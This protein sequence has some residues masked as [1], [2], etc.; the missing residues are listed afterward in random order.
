MT[1]LFINMSTVLQP[2]RQ[3]DDNMTITGV[4]GGDTVYH[5]LLANERDFS[6]GVGGT[7]EGFRQQNTA[8]ESIHMSWDEVG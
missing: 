2:K 4:E 1:E 3:S 7:Y 5:S 6:A 8:S